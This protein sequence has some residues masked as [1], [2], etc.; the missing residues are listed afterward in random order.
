[1]SRMQGIVLIG[2]PSCGKSTVGV[3]LAKAAGLRFIDT[4]LLIQED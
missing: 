4:D 1:M 2:M 3:L